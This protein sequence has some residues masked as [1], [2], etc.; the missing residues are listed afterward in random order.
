MAA[1]SVRYVRIGTQINGKPAM[2]RVELATSGAIQLAHALIKIVT[3]FDMS[4]RIIQAR[5][6]ARAS[7]NT[8]LDGAGID[9]RVWGMNR[10][11]RWVIV[12]LFRECG[13]SASWYR[14]WAG[15]EHLHIGANL[16]NTWTYLAYQVGAVIAG[17]DGLGSGGR[18]GRDTHPKPSQ[19]RTVREGAAW[20]QNQLIVNGQ[21]GLPSTGDGPTAPKPVTPTTP[22]P[23][24]EDVLS[25]AQMTELKDEIRKEGQAT[26]EYVRL[27]VEALGEAL[28]GRKKLNEI[29]QTVAEFVA[30]AGFNRNII[31]RNGESAARQ[32]AAI[33]DAKL[34][35]LT[36]LRNDIKAAGGGAITDADLARIE[37]VFRTSLETAPITI[38]GNA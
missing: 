11:A 28:G 4:A 7:A 22:T 26:R 33:I 24:K 8:H 34:D 3:G 12:A 17:F 21:P 31:E 13:F 32:T 18:A 9:Y 15:N 5:G 37:T 36:G 25:E 20:A 29:G 23:P 6:G 35:A 38:G 27:R 2:V 19:W 30:K 14:D 10:A 1:S 16:G